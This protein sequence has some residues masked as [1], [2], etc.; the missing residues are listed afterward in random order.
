MS[1]LQE[2]N[3]VVLGIRTP[4]S[5]QSLAALITEQISQFSSQ[6]V[7]KP[8]K[9]VTD[10]SSG[11]PHRAG[12]RPISFVRQ[13][14][15]VCLYPELL[16]E[17]SL[18]LDVR[19]RAQRLLDTCNGGSVG[20][21]SVA[22]CGIPQVLKAV[23]EFITR[24]DGG[25][26]SRSE[27]I[28]FS[29]GSQMTLTLFFH[30]LASGE[31]EA[32]TGVLTPMPC[33]HTLPIL[34]DVTG[35]ALVPYRLVEERGWAVDLDEL[36][37]AVTTARGR[38][39]PRAIYISNPGNPTGHV[40]DR[41]TIEKVIRFAATEHLILLVEE[42][43]QD[44][45]YGQDKEFMSY[46]KVL[47][48]M[49][50]RYSETVELVSF[51]SI[52]TACLGECGLRGGYMEVVN[53]DPAVKKYLSN[54]HGF[55]SPPVLPQLALELM[56]NP[57]TSGDSSYNTYTKKILHIKDTLSQNAQQAC[58]FLN[59]LPGMSC[60]PAMGG[61]FLYPRLHLTPPVIKEAK[62]LGV[63]AD[64]L[65]CQKLL[66]EEGVCLGAG[67][68]NRQEDTN[69][70]IRLCVLAAPV[71]LEEVLARLRSFHLRLLDTFPL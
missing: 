23:A 21:Y 61:V 13:V 20:S 50:K 10:V 33:P 29:S 32:Q 17:E 1:S 54:M 56:V 8:F 48:E 15:A 70:H 38:C 36:H 65:Y 55:S 41:E 4:T 39:Q 53:M 67:C 3:P 34:L 71:T 58:E 64:V 59:G 25:V 42:V 9:R 66:E 35:I 24:R 49:G 19:Q 45:V 2:V 68:E 12:M 62:M 51:H 52:L 27:D 7:N 22:A 14:L 30:L 5:L 37:R 44:S 18:H 60:Q 69:F 46:K 47:F 28:I 57:P 16:K 43:Y 63:E 6:G 26:C 40:Q 11:D 31:G